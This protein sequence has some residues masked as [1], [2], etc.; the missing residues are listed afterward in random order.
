[1]V[2]VHRTLHIILFTTKGTK[3]SKKTGGEILGLHALLVSCFLFVS[4]CSSG[5]PA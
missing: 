5:L 3:T 4:W 1:M 2:T